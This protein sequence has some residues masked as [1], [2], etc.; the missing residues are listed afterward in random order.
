MKKI[1]ENIAFKYSPALVLRK[2]GR[3]SYIP[4]R[5]KDHLKLKVNGGYL[6]ILFSAIVLIEG[7]DLACTF[8]GRWLH[9]FGTLAGAGAHHQGLRWLKP[10]QFQRTVY[11]HCEC[12]KL[13]PAARFQLL[14]VCRSWK[15]G[16]K[17]SQPCL[18]G[19][20]WK[21]QSTMEVTGKQLLHY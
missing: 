4:F 10:C 15:R 11:W 21:F 8:S 2:I 1:V 5:V 19:K 9:C 16:H 20:I 3:F 7:L 18:T 6:K 12:D 14:A 13:R 17:V